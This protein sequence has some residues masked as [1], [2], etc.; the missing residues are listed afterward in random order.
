MAKSNKQRFGLFYRSNGRWAGPYGGLTFT[1][2]TANL[3]NTKAD[4]RLLAN[5]LLKS[6]VKVR[7]V[8]VG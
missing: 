4:I 5:Y 7:P 1:K 8:T 6:R 3:T 2:Y